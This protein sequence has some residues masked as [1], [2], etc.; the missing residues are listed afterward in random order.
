MT[1]HQSELIE[2]AR[3]WAMRVADPAFVAWDDLSAWLEL[4]PAHLAAYEAAVEDDE[5]AAATLANAG[6][7]KDDP[8]RRRR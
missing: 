6:S 5:W 1:T 8:H 3:R 2:A 4:S 7:A